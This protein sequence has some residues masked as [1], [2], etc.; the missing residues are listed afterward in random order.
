MREEKDEIESIVGDYF[1]TLFTSSRPPIDVEDLDMLDTCVTNEMKQELDNINQHSGLRR[2]E[3]IN[4][5]SLMTLLPL[6]S[7]T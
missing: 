7:T 4:P 1:K 6:K 2:K 5:S 3:N